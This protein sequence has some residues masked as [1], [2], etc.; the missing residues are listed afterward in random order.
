MDSKAFDAAISLGLSSNNWSLLNEWITLESS[1]TYN[2][3]ATPEDEHFDDGIY[4]RIIDLLNQEDFLQSKGSF[5]VLLTLEYDWSLLTETQKRKLLPELAK[6]YPNFNESMAWFLI[7][8]LLGEYYADASSLEVLLHLKSVNLD[9]ARSLIVMGL[10]K[11]VKNS[12]DK[13]VTQKA[14]A[15][16]LKMKLDSSEIVRNEVKLSMQRIANNREST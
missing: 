8:E 3:G 16:L 9:E 2:Y 1:F 7:A 13:V 15:E 6:A 10:E 14:Y 12:I 5:N 4:T 11:V